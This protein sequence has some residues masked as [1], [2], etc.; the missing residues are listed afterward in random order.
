MFYTNL[1]MA[2]LKMLFS[3]AFTTEIAEIA[4]IFLDFLRVLCDL[5]GK[6]VLRHRLR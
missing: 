1:P 6:M 5:S 4:E 3:K 2:F